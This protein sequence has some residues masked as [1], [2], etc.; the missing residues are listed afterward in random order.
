MEQKLSASRPNDGVQTAENTKI[1]SGRR[2]AASAICVGI[3]LAISL[4]LRR[5]V[6]INSVDLFFLVA[7]LVVAFRFG[8]IASLL[9]CITSVLAYNFFFLPPLYTFRIADPAN[10]ATL[11]VFLCVAAI[12][13]NLGARMRG[14]TITAQARAR[15]TEAL[16]AFSRKIAGIADLDNLLWATAFQIASMLKLDVVF[17]LP[18]NGNLVVR[19]GYPPEDR[20]DEAEL[21]AAHWAWTKNRPAGRGADTLPGTRWLFLPLRT[22]RGAVGAMGI[23]RERDG[24]LLNPDERRLVDALAD[25][26]AVAIER[27]RLADD[28]DEARIAAETERLRGALLTSLSHDLKTPLAS[29]LGAAT[30]LREYKSLYDVSARDVLVETIQEEAER[31]SRF[32]ANLLDMTRIESGQI[33][34]RREPVDVGEVVGT[35]LRRVSR[36]LAAHRI[37]VHMPK[38]LPLLNLDEVLFE[39]VLVNLLDNAAKYAPAGTAV[40]IAAH[41]RGDGGVAIEVRDRGTGIPPEDLDRIFEKF[42]R[43]RKGDHKQAGTGLGLAICAGFVTSLGGTIRASN[44]PDGLGATFTIEFPPS[45]RATPEPDDADLGA[46]AKGR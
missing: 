39:Q 37:E 40:A 29:I 6:G 27:I 41:D 16:Y 36:L 5:L 25:Q 32:V 33:E 22:G 38:D 24:P 43:A 2:F 4:G 26:A 9:A 10:I 8:L 3:A 21:D 34:L 18:E 7:I 44:R 14:Q 1:F 15:T 30:A 42:Y 28:V 11:F 31:L 35:A 19:A 13:S 46:A 12:A 45:V 20:L 17:L 23:S